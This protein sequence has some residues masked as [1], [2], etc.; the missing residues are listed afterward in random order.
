MAL[1]FALLTP[2]WIG[3]KLPLAV[4]ALLVYGITDVS[5]WALLKPPCGLLS[6]QRLYPVKQ[7]DP[8]R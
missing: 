1:T 6:L 2:G 5:L 3:R 4:G 8:G 7:C